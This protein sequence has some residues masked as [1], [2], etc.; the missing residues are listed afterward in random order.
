MFRRI[1]T[2]YQQVK[3]DF[4]LD[5]D[6]FDRR[7]GPEI[8]ALIKPLKAANIP[9]CTTLAVDDRIYQKLYAPEAFLERPENMYQ[10]QGYLEAFLQG[11]EKHQVQFRRQW[12]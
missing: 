6:A 3:P 2:A 8:S 5:D 1:Q 7:Y 11:K 12:I 4:N 9:I 10:A